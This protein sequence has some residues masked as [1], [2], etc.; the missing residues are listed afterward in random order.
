MN[1]NSRRSTRTFDLPEMR[2]VHYGRG[3]SSRLPEA[4][5]ELGLKRPLLVTSPSVSNG[6]IGRSVRESLGGLAIGVFTEVRSHAPAA[7][8]LEAIEAAR[9]YRA[10]GVISL[11]GGSAIDT[12]KAVSMS[13]PEGVHD[14]DSLQALSLTGGMINSPLAAEPLPHIS[15]P[16]TLGSSEFTHSFTV[17]NS[18]TKMKD[19][20]WDRRVVP[21]IAFLDADLAIHTPDW[22]WASTGIKTVDHCIE[23]YLSLG[24]TPFTDALV[25]HALKELRDSLPLA[26]G[27]ERDADARQRCQIAAWMSAFGALNVVGGLSHAIGHH[28]G[29]RAGLVHG[30][31]TSIVL[32]AVLEFNRPAT[33]ER[34]AALAAAMGSDTTGL[35][36]NSSACQLISALNEL[37]ISMRL[38]RTLAEAGIW[39]ADLSGVARA[40]MNDPMLRNNPRYVTLDDIE[41]LLG[42]I[43]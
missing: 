43:R 10:D 20:Y 42:S 11:G 41:A 39:D 40:A 5:A 15:L 37:I 38:P 25:L 22:L 19:M 9:A 12:A 26:V 33:V 23:W 17:T 1:S 31:T 34:Q 13:M 16:T 35:D 14:V 3:C 27:Q 4:I 29:P 18:A 30:H 2:R 21:Q 32:P 7:A 24:R 8:V 6:P 36:T 28:L